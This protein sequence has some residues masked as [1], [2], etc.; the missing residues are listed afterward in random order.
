MRGFR[1]RAF[2]GSRPPP[3]S[4]GQALLPPLTSSTIA[5]ALAGW[6]LARCR[7]WLAG[8]QAAASL[9]LSWVWAWAC[10]RPPPLA[11]RQV[12]CCRCHGNTAGVDSKR[13][14]KNSG[15]TLSA[16]RTA[17]PSAVARRPASGVARRAASGGALGHTHEGSEPDRNDG[18]RSIRS[19]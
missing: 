10:S 2:T 16:G 13:C 19:E 11:G 1:S 3:P 7:P 5:P 4:P 15:G 14:K 18:S 17:P 6:H 12:G 9:P 8:R